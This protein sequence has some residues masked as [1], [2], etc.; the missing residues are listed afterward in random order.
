MSKQGLFNQRWFLV[1]ILLAS[2]V[3]GFHLLHPNWINCKLAEGQEVETLWEGSLRR[4]PNGEL[5]NR[6][7]S[8]GENV[9]VVESRYTF[10]DST[11]WVKVEVDDGE[12]GWMTIEE[13]E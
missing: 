12:K 2:A 3:V 7:L 9:L 1:A 11:C 4:T 13:W 10:G 6:V 8:A 5:G